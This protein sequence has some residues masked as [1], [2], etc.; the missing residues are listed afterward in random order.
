MDDLIKELKNIKTRSSDK[1]YLSMNKNYSPIDIDKI[2]FHEIENLKDD[3]SELTFID[4]GQAILFESA[5][6]CIGFIRTAAITYDYNKRTSKNIKEFYILVKDDDGKFIIRTFPKND[7]NDMKFDPEDEKLKYGIDKASCARILSVVRR[8][9]ELKHASRF[10]NPILDGT[11]EARYPYEL[12]F[13]NE[14]KKVSALAK[15]CS[16]TTNTGFGI[17]N[18]LMSLNDGAW[19]YYPIVKNNNK[20]HPAEIYF[21]KL[22]DKSDYVFRFE[23][24]GDDAPRIIDLLMKNAKDPVFLGYPYGLV[25]ADNTARVS[26]QEKKMLQTQISVKLG[27][28]WPG[29][30]KMLKS[31]NAHEILDNIKF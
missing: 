2:N 12:D 31:M 18:Y 30:S 14:L 23:N 4:G 26:E 3:S 19:Y 6:F 24:K 7:F 17:T 20:S 13:I 5:G 8:F 22:N 1:C 27:K 9:A 21:L 25:D 11:L 16:L 10:D 29:F 28:E 15:T